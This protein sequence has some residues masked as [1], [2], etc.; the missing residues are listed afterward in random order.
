MY[1]IS[2]VVVKKIN[3]NINNLIFHPSAMNNFNFEL[4]FNKSTFI[5]SLLS[6]YQFAVSILIWYANN[7]LKAKVKLL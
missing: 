2:Y 7:K 4:F 1:P 3:I 5:L 6:A